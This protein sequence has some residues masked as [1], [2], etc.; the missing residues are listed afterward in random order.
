MSKQIAD[1]LTASTGITV[2]HGQAPGGQLVNS[3][4]PYGVVYRV[5]GVQ[6]IDQVAGFVG[7]QFGMRCGWQVKCVGLSEYQAD[8]LADRVR[9]GITSHETVSFST[10]ATHVSDRQI[11]SDVSQTDGGVTNVDVTFEAL[12]NPVM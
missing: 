1:A 4:Y 5:A 7:G 6:R 11:V 10:T 8:R 2:H 12:C 3:D 9:A